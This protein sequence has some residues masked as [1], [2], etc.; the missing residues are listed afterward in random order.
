[1]LD[2]GSGTGYGTSYLAD[3]GAKE[4]CGVDGDR[5]AIAFSRQQFVQ[6]NLRFQ[7]SDLRSLS[8]F[9]D[10]HFDVIFASNSLE[11]VEGVD[12]FFKAVWR[13]LNEHGVLIVAVPAAR[14]KSDV[15]FELS[16]PHHV[17]I[18]SPDHWFRTQQ[19]YFRTVR[20]FTH[21]LTSEGAKLSPGNKPEETLIR[22]TDFTFREG[23]LSNLYSRDTYTA[24]FVSSDPAPEQELPGGGL[25]AQILDFSVSRKVRS[26]WVQPFQWAYHKVCY[27]VRYQGLSA[28]PGRT[29]SFIRRSWPL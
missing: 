13:L 29:W 25:P 18:W 7:Q 11:H 9:P 2:A 24:I 5:K 27:V 6:S 3:H 26:R 17:N 21:S 28:L 20:C 16:N 8:N 19:Q 1:M 22:E 10:R 14:D 12:A 23:P 4:I 15:A